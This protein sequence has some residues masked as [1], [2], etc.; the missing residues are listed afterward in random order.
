M[1]A[2]QG[3]KAVSQFEW[4]IADEVSAWFPDPPCRRRT[5]NVRRAIALYVALG[6]WRKVALAM[7]FQTHSVWHAVNRL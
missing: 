6:N 3:W 7:G 1:T 2:L 5:I 4:E